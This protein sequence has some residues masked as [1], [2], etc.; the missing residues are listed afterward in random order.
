MTRTGKYGSDQLYGRALAQPRSPL[1]TGNPAQGPTAGSLAE[2]EVPRQVPPYLP[3]LLYILLHLTHG[4]LGFPSTFSLSCCPP[5]QPTRLEVRLLPV[6]GA[7]PSLLSLAQGRPN[8][9]LVLLSALSAPTTGGLRV[10]K[11]HASGSHAKVQILLC[12]PALHPPCPA[13]KLSTNTSG[14]RPASKGSAAWSHAKIETTLPEVIPSAAPLFPHLL[15][16]GP[17][18]PPATTP[19]LLRYLQPRPSCHPTVSRGLLPGI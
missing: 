7:M 18:A 16:L 10:L 9:L 6:L 19:K 4:L 3:L 12:Y 11:G 1:R 13:A 17:R 14:G 8:P 2:I 5:F 15:T